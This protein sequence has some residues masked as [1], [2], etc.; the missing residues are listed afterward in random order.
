MAKTKTN[1]RSAITGKYVTKNTAKR[2][3][4]TTV[5]E[6]DKVKSTRKP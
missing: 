5:K 1:Y 2:H 3:P 6:T 4:K